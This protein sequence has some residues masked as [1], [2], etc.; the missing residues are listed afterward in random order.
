MAKTLIF[1]CNTQKKICVL[2]EISKIVHNHCA[3]AYNY[4]IL[5]GAYPAFVGCV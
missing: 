4:H 3:L 5:P 1:F 2:S